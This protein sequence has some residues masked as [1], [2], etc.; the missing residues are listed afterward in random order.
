MGDTVIRGNQKKVWRFVTVQPDHIPGQYI[1][2]QA[3]DG[4]WEEPDPTDPMD[5]GWRDA[6]VPVA[7]R[8]VLMR[9]D[10]D[11]AMRNVHSPYNGDRLSQR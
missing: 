2:V 7:T 8:V 4:H 10:K 6:D 1:C 5:D 3:L 11:G 9:M